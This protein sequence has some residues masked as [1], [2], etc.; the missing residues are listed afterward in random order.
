[1]KSVSILYIILAVIVFSSCSGSK[2]AGLS[3]APSLDGDV[4][5]RSV[6]AGEVKY[7]YKVVPFDAEG[8]AG[9]ESNVAMATI[10][11]DTNPPVWITDVGITLVQDSPGGV[12]AFWGSATDEESPPVTYNV[13]WQEG[14]TLDWASATKIEDVS[15]PYFLPV[16]EPGI[17]IS[18]GVRSQD[19]AEPPNE[20]ANDSV[21][22]HTVAAAED[23]TAPSWDVEIGLLTAVQSGEFVELTW[24]TATD[25]DSPPV[26]FALDWISGPVWSESAAERISEVES[27]YLFGPIEEGLTYHFRIRALDSA[28]PPNEDLNDIVKTVVAQTPVN[29]LIRGSI[30]YFANQIPKMA[31]YGSYVYAAGAFD[32][33][34]ALLIFDFSD[35][36]NPVKVGTMFHPSNRSATRLAVNESLKRLYISY[37]FA[38]LDIYD[39]TDPVGPALIG[40]SDFGS[41]DVAKMVALDDGT[42]VNRYGVNNFM[43][44]DASDP[45][46][47]SIYWNKNFGSGNSFALLGN[48][49]LVDDDRWVHVL[50]LSLKEVVDSWDGGPDWWAYNFAIFGDQALVYGGSQP[51]SV[52]SPRLFDISGIPT[53]P[54]PEVLPNILLGIFAQNGNIILELD[55]SG[56][57]K[58]PGLQRMR[59]LNMSNPAIPQELEVW[60]YAEHL[61]FGA[62]KA[63]ISGGERRFYFSTYKGDGNDRIFCLT[64]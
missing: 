49:V 32:D 36:D 44:L 58:P 5:T 42:L 30:S 18:I 21:F 24:G 57:V 2:Q 51:G 4:S 34:P 26:V 12:T 38:P 8:S 46:D 53:L 13:Y 19:S 37:N 10:G 43:V 62:P 1:M 15:S 50:D 28:A 41:G 20:D 16:I 29:V 59:L 47:V 25:A 22:T 23:N 63:A 60:N 31:H 64:Y 54:E 55:P 35:P 40:S 56:Q 17:T 33:K 3:G 7:V 48:Y 11:G 14:V 27:P 6:S 52:P 45:N 9:V 61:E 39:L